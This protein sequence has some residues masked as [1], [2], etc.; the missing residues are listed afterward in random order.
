LA[1]YARVDDEI[2]TREASQCTHHGPQFGIDEIQF[3]TLPG[4]ARGTVGLD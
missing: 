1:F 2:A 4:I 3:D